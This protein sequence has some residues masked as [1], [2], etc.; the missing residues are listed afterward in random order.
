M[1]ISKRL[2]SFDVDGFDEK[3]DEYADVLGKADSLSRSLEY[4]SKALE[5]YEEYLD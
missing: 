3:V 5:P 4:A 2:I 1:A